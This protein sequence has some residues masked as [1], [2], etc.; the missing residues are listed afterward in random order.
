MKYYYIKGALIADLAEGLA[1]ECK[2]EK[3]KIGKK[4]LKRLTADF[5]YLKPLAQRDPETA[6]ML[7][8]FTE[9]Q[10]LQHYLRMRAHEAIYRI[11]CEIRWQ[12]PNSKK[13]NISEAETMKIVLITM[14]ER[15]LNIHKNSKLELFHWR[16]KTFEFALS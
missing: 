6:I 16:K 15:Y 8:P 4:R 10:A 3:V 7:I 12:I 5:I 2:L 1:I 14:L 11:G 13:R 9:Q